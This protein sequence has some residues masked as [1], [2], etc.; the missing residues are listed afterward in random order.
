M[1]Q[2]QTQGKSTHHK[3]N[4][5][6]Q[7]LPNFKDAVE[8]VHEPHNVAIA[9]GKFVHKNRSENILISTPEE[10]TKHKEYKA[11]VIPPLKNSFFFDHNYDH[12]PGM[13]F[14]EAVRQMSVHVSHSFLNVPFG[15]VFII[16][17]MGF[18]FEHYA[19][20]NDPIILRWLPDTLTFKRDTFRRGHGVTNI[21]QNDK[22]V[23]HVTGAWATVP[24][25]V[26]KRAK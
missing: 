22:K 4:P 23:G 5:S 19:N 16:Q 21:I 20:L 2:E 14:V 9:E 26:L 7:H 8:I 3:S 11:F 13:V 17:E 18:K 12:I 6:P 24:E 15:D 10:I 1:K 25:K